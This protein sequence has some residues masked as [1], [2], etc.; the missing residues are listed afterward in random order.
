LLVLYYGSKTAALIQLLRL[1]LL[2]KADAKYHTANCHTVKNVSEAIT[3]SKARELGLQPC[4]ICKPATVAPQ[5]PVSSNPQGTGTETTQCSGLTKAGTRCKHMT[6]I[7]N[8]YCFQHQ[9]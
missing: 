4:K 3:I 7:A 2:Q 9:P 6:R 1:L 8:G 5:N